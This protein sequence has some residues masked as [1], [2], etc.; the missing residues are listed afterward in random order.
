MMPASLPLLKPFF[1][2]PFDATPQEIQQ[3]TIIKRPLSQSL[4]LELM[5]LI[6]L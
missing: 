1:L 6:I 4:K 5:V 3:K 2:F